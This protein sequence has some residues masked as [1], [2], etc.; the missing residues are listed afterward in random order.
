MLPSYILTIDIT[1]E[2]P[3]ID[4]EKFCKQVASSLVHLDNLKGAF[5]RSPSTITYFPPDIQNY[6]LY[7]SVRGIV[8]IS[9]GKQRAEFLNQLYQSISKLIML[10]LPHLKV[11]A[12][13]SKFQFS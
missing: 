9:I 10:E 1:S 13:I 12:E 2:D 4:E 8:M 5:D 11:T 6:R 3:T 7:W